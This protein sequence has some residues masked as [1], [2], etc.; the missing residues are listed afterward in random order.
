MWGTGDSTSTPMVSLD[1]T[2]TENI[3]ARDLNVP[4]GHGELK[5]HGGQVLGLK[6]ICIQMKH[7]MDYRSINDQ[8]IPNTPVFVV[9]YE[10]NPSGDPCI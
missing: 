7:Y 8:S 2:V 10:D 6:L 5:H 3:Y 9:L 1:M 4:D